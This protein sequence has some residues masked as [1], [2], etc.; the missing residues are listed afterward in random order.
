MT[1]SWCKLDLKKKFQKIFVE[2]CE[3]KHDF[4]LPNCSQGFWEQNH[5]IRH[6]S[7][8]RMKVDIDSES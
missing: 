4:V 6:N 5:C 8:D 1:P 7:E 2:N 3:K